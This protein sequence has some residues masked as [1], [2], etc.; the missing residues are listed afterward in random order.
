MS[1]FDGCL[2]I[3]CTSMAIER[4]GHL[5]GTLF[6]RDCVRT[7]AF[8]LRDDTSTSAPDGTEAELEAT[9]VMITRC[10]HTSMA[11]EGVDNR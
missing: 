10:C 8:Q 5:M 2:A 9:C 3:D 6:D 1:T 4:H 7:L 11:S